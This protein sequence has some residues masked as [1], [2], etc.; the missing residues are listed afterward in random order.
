MLVSVPQGK[1]EKVFV[2]LEPE[3]WAQ[4]AELKRV[5]GVE[6]TPEVVR[7]L[8]RQALAATPW[9]SSTLFSAREGLNSVKHWAFGRLRA[10]LDEISQEIDQGMG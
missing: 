5:L 6:S 3:I 10:K 7:I 2:S 1:S 4:V 9:D 8:I